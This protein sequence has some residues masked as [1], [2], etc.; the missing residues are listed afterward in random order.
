MYIKFEEI[1]AMSDQIRLLVDDDQDTFLDTLD[2]ETNAMDILG[3]LVQER[4]ECKANEIAMKDLAKTYSQRSQRLASKQDAI[5]ITIGHLLDA[6]G[7]TKIMHPIATVSRTKPRAKL[8][9]VDEA[10]IPSQLGTFVFK[11][12][13]KAI[14]NQMDDGELVPGCEMTVGD[15]SISVRI[16]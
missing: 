9:I 16:K 4:T 13:L 14:K 5:S 3:L 15:A 1:K 8:V 10:E 2:G 6:M 11:P 7:E 12:D